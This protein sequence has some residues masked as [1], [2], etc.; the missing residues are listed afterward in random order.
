MAVY[1]IQAQFPLSQVFQVLGRDCAPLCDMLNVTTTSACSEICQGI[2]DV[3]AHARLPTGSVS[4]SLT[5]TGLNSMMCY[6]GAAVISI[7][8]SAIIEHI[9][10]IHRGTSKPSSS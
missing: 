2:D 9:E 7:T 10:E 6:C 8:A 1:H 3:A 5:M 4:A